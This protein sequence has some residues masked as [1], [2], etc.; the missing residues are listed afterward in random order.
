MAAESE[1]AGADAFEG[2]ASGGD[3]AVTDA[4]AAKAE[5]DGAFAEFMLRQLKQCGHCCY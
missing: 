1:V 4:D 2:A 5:W 3:A